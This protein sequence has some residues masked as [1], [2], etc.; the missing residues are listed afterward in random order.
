VAANYWTECRER[1]AAGLRGGRSPGKPFFPLALFIIFLS[2]LA[3][4]RPV[5]AAIPASVCGDAL[6]SRLQFLFDRPA[7]A[8]AARSF[9]L[10]APLPLKSA[11]FL[12]REA[13]RHADLL[14]PE[15][16]FVLARP[17]DASDDSPYFG[18]G[19]AV[20]TFDSPAGHAKIHYTEDPASP[21]VVLGADNIKATIPA[22]V[23][24]VADAV[25]SSW[26]RMFGEMGYRPPPRDRVAGG[27]HRL[28]VYLLNL[29][30]YGYTTYDT[31]PADVY[32]VIENDFNSPLM[33]RNLYAYDE[34]PATDPV[35]GAM[36]T[37]VAH[38][39]FHASHFQY[40]TDARNQWWMEASAVWMENELYPAVKDYLN[41]LGAVYDDANDN[42]RWD[43]G[44]TYYAV[45]GRTALGTTSRPANRWFDLPYFSLDYFHAVDFI[46]YPYGTAI[47][48]FYLDERYGNDGTFIRGVWDL[49]GGGALALQ[50]I[51][52]K[53]HEG[54]TDLATAYQDFQ[55]ANFR[56]T[57]YVDWAYYP[58]IRHS[59]AFD[60]FPQVIDGT[61]PSLVLDH[62]S[63]RF[64]AFKA[65][66]ATSTLKLV[67]EQMN[68]GNLAVRLLL[69]K[70][71]TVLIDEAVVLD[72]ATV[73]KQVGGFGTGGTYD[74][75]VAVVMNV[76]SDLDGEPFTISAEK[77][78]ATT[79][80]TIA[81]ASGGG[82]GGGCFIAT[83]VY[84][85]DLAPEVMV[86]RSF[87]DRFLL[88]NGPGR[89]FVAFYYE[90]SPPLAAL[91]A[92]NEPLRALTR[93][94]LT[95]LVYAVKYPL[96]AFGC[97]ALL[98]LASMVPGRRKGGWARTG[99]APS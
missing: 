49:I 69:M 78:A 87:R 51:D 6:N 29:N 18:N 85:S 53:L 45:D 55:V 38:E 46:L 59:G 11:T 12:M 24:Q 77:E 7:A 80:A 57:G 99:A 4:G 5:W 22:F 52:T 25:D 16:H 1:R 9:A 14:A 30:A 82:G 3:W 71:G 88:S 84:G 68:S 94:G 74:R 60:S 2:V 36:Q 75:V 47:W 70:A 28:D 92:G 35:L 37:T 40:T 13:A 89:L 98:L 33:Q 48:A 73:E 93:A 56:R 10:P 21:H 31:S 41:Y 66:E 83:A 58:L 19:I 62:L 44:E 26:A 97:A 72:R 54:G 43:S 8:S 76:S 90:Q 15:N 65:D 81:P 23:E 79:A 86:L 27:D 42:G 39:L 50:A 63:A 61:T 91:I 64:Y 20:W 96:A 34:D 95:P 67:F 17:T 32:L